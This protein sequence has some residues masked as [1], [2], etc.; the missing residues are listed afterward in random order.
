MTR[1]E[2]VIDWDDGEVEVH[3]YR[4]EKEAQEA[5]DE[6]KRECGYQIHKMTIRRIIYG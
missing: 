2:L 6:Y 4:T 1:Y 5:Q 3:G